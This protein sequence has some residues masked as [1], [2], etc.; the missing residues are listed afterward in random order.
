MTIV[1]ERNLVG[2]IP[3]TSYNEIPINERKYM[4]DDL[5]FFLSKNASCDCQIVPVTI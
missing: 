1:N 2:L 3:Q 4:T 5:Q